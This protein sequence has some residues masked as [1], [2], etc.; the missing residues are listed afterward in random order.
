MKKL[1]SMYFDCGRM[2]SLE[3]LFVAEEV[4]LDNIIGCELYFGE[5]LGKHSDISGE[6]E[7]GDIT[8]VSEDQDKINWLVDVVGS[9]TI[10]G[11]NPFQYIPEPTC[12]ECGE[13]EDYCACEDG[14]Q[15]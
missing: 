3:G 13:E 2:G 4:Q 8:I 15:E 14:F 9:T 7:K 5:C 1:Y 11:Y 10:S 12:V 6:L